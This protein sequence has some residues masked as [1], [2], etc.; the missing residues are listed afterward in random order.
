[1]KVVRPTAMRLRSGTSLAAIALAMS[2]A[3]T[4]AAQQPAPAAQPGAPADATAQPG[5]DATAQAG[6]A[7]DV[8]E[9]VVTGFRAALGSALNEKRKESGVVDVIKAEDIADFPDANLAESIQRVPGVSIA[10]DAGE[11][12]QITVR[13]LSPQF[14]RVK[15]NGMEGQSTT[16]GTDSSGG[17]NRSR[18]FDFNVFASELFNSITVRKTPS[19]ETEEGSLGATVDLA[20]AR[21]FDYKDFTFAF[22]AQ[23]GYN[24]LS[25][26][27]DPRVSSLVSG[28]FADGKFGALLSVAY[29]KRHLREEGFGTVGWDRSTTN[30]GFCAPASATLTTACSPG[31]P[32]SSTDAAFGAVNNDNTFHPRIPRYGRLTHEQERLGITGSLQWQPADET[33]FS[34]DVL[35]SQFD[36]T[37]REDWLEAFSF[38]RPASANGKPQTSVRDAT[39]DPNGNLVYGLFDGVDIRSESRYDELE[40]I[41]NQYTLTGSHEFTDALK[42]DGLVGYSKSELDNP[43]QTTVTIDRANTSGYSWDFR[44][45]DRL[46]ALNYGFDVTNPANYVFAPAGGAFVGSEIRLRPQTVDNEYKVAELNGSYEVVPAF[47]IK[48]GA[49]WKKFTYAST[50]QQRASETTIPALPPGTTIADL[51]TLLSGFGRNLDVPEG[52]PTTWLRPD[53]EKFDEVFGIYS[54]T[55]IFQLLGVESAGARGNIAGVTEEVMA[56][57]TQ[58]QFSFDELPIPIRGDIGVRFARTKQTSRGYQV[59]AGAP[60]EVTARREYNDWLPSLNL[61]GEVTPDFL[62]RLSASKVMSRPGLGSLTPGGTINLVGVRSVSSGNPTLEP[63]RANTFDASAEWY[64]APDSLL[65]VGFFYKDVKTFIQ[66]LQET[67]PFNTSGLSDALLQGSTAVP[68]DLFLFTRPVNTKGGPLKGVEINYQQPFTFLPEPF[69]NFGAILNYTYVTSEISYFVSALGTAQV[70]NDLVGLSKNAYNATLY[71]EDDKFSARVSAAYRD[72]YLTAVPSNNV[73]N[74]VN[75]TNSTLTL[76]AS[77]SYAITDRIKV[78]FEALNLTDEFNDQYT[79]STRDSVVFYSHTGRQFNLGVQYKF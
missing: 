14:T 48:A 70:E 66:N 47:T 9:V 12:R 20:T 55:G 32:R 7:D 69:Q 78:T 62:V 11:G 79:S 31:N 50:A 56:G 75:G 40:T 21:P 33:L 68:T 1:M 63:I 8:T 61:V 52:T 65:S 57:Y 53:V 43:I 37:R 60:V 46:P 19:A 76:D 59:V 25:K 15:I 18:A 35:R 13:G 45:D 38:S 26:K 67:R 34:F 58:G 30:G 27:F 36:A 17:N 2:L 51:T 28:T 72:K 74:D 6:G 23:E 44:E 73:G 24:D 22:S 3:G 16:G 4:A 5:D 64:F 49:N 42:I 10:R 39:V 41:Y 71:Y 54:G 29:T 77:A